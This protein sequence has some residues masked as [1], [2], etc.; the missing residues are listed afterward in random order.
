MQQP[1]KMLGYDRTITVFS[2]QGRLY[3]VE[4]AREA[5]KKGTVSLGIVYEDGVLLGAD[6]N[7]TEDLMVPDS[8]EKIYQVA[9]HIGSVTSGLVADGRSL[10]D[11]AR[12]IAQSHKMTFDKS[13]PVSKLTRD[14]C[15]Y[16][17]MHTQV[18]GVRPF[19]TALLIAGVNEEPH[20]FET[21]P[22]GSYWEYKATAIGENSDEVRD[23][24]KDKYEE[25]MSREDAV[26]LALHAF[27][28][29][30]EERFNEKS[31]E[32]A[33]VSADGEFNKLSESEIKKGIKK[34]LK[35]K[36]GA[37]KKKKGK[38][39]KEDKSEEKSDKE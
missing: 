15:D 10:V 18:A 37:K 26:D 24:L 3:Q 31:L 4:Y 11:K 9:E 12:V 38:K 35:E 1:S 6:K 33:Y 25:G 17:Q 13:I 7:V 36:K 39:S 22:S 8:V 34:V 14:L 21:D 28:V 16:E 30:T 19:G 27:H 32:L 29:G 2:P 23:I 5:V 20:I